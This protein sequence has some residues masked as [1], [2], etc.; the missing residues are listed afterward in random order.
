MDNE[1]VSIETNDKQ[2]VGLVFPS[3]YTESNA[4]KRHLPVDTEPGLPE[5]SPSSFLR[6]VKKTYR[7]LVRKCKSISKF[8]QRE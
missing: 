6:R 4:K 8:R 7:T 1:G 2:L 3:A 5:S